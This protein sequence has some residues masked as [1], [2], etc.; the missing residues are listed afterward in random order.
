[1]T[2][3]PDPKKAFTEAMQQLSIGADL[4][5]EFMRQASYVA[6]WVYRHA[7]AEDQ[8]RRWEE[9][10]DLLFSKLYAEYREQEPGSKEND[11]K[12]Y[13]RQDASYKEAQIRL[14]QARFTASVFKGF[15]RAFE[16]KRDMLMMLGADRRKEMDSTDLDVKRRRAERAIKKRTRQ[17]RGDS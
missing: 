8:V 6:V 9:H 17:R 15:T 12:A 11:C 14:R 13:I 7:R 16:Q 3:S 1:M 5:R 10:A 4:T 2:T